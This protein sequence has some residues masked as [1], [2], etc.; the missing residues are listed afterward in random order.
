MMAVKHVLQK[1]QL[2][3]TAHNNQ[4]DKNKALL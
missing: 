4:N 2:L 1:L 3:L